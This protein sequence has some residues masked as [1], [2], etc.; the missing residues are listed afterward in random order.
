M[1]KILLSPWLSLLTLSLIIGLRVSD[2]TFVE[3]I[4][5]RYFD[6]LISSQPVKEDSQI[7]IVNIDDATIQQYGQYPFPRDKYKDII[8]ELYNRNAGLV[9]FNVFM[10]DKD[11]FGKDEQFRSILQNAPIIL[12]QVATND[13]IDFGTGFNPGVAEIGE[14]AKDW[15]PSYRSIHPSIFN[16]AAGIGIANTLPEIDGVVRRIPMLITAKDILY[17]SIILETLRVA[18][19]DISFQVKTSESGIEAVRIP[20]YGKIDTDSNGRIWI[21]WSYRPKFYSF[22]SLPESFDGKIVIVGVTARGLGNPVATA[23]GEQ[24][25]HQLQGALLDTILDK[26]NISR[27]LWSDVAEI[28]ITVLLSIIAILLTR[29]K[30]GFIP[31]LVII[32]SLYS[33]SGFIFST[34]KFLIDITIPILGI[35]LVYAHSYTV[36]FVTELNAKLQ[37][38]KQFGTYLSPALVEKLQKNPELL[39][40]GGERRQLS[41]MFT[42]VRGF[43][44]ISEHYGD[45]VEG[46]TSIMNRY[47][48]AMTA[49]IIENNGTLDKYIGDAQMAFWNAPLDEQ[50][51][52]KRSEEH[53][54]ELQSH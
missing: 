54:S 42:D 34:Y 4:R 38:K 20:Q 47:M 17:P 6:T 27:P 32:G 31:V 45:N 36:K 35:F 46:L 37:I 41:I 22:N 28:G 44:S 21:D 48:T 39:R 30:Y 26:S 43:T 25:P 14:S 13:D 23:I 40:L 10:P 9:V 5:L 53:T 33:G 50:Y 8:I 1:K 12:P 52:A 2:P 49:K 51:H 16:E 19:G 15:T 18:A 29:W 3:S 24:Y 7:A 11:R